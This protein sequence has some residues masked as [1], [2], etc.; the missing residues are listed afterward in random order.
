MIMETLLPTTDPTLIDGAVRELTAAGVVDLVDA[1]DYIERARLADAVDRERVALDR[2]Q[3]E[4]ERITQERAGL[5]ERCWR[6]LV[7]AGVEARIARGARTVAPG[8]VVTLTETYY[9]H[10]HQSMLWPCAAEDAGFARGGFGPEDNCGAL[11]IRRGLFEVVLCVDGDVLLVKTAELRGDVDTAHRRSV[12]R[13][14]T[15]AAHA[16]LRVSVRDREVRMLDVARTVV[17]SGDVDH[18]FAWLLGVSID[19]VAS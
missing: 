17:F 13:L 5:M 4:I 19:E 2:M 11:L 14:R 10:G 6:D 1:V 15:A 18:A 9:A 8:D 7:D 16:G 12:A 3:S